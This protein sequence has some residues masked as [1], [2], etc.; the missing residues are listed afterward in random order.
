MYVE[1][2]ANDLSN[3]EYRDFLK[4]NSHFSLE[5][6]SSKENDMLISSTFHAINKKD[7]EKEV[8]NFINLFR[9]SL[10][11]N[12]VYYK[13]KNIVEGNF[14]IGYRAVVSDKENFN[15]LIEWCD[16]YQKINM[17]KSTSSESKVV[18]ENLDTMTM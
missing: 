5:I 11:I 3:D 4:K 14:F 9:N 18:D 2:V 16:N 6:A 8:D 10:D 12:A 13:D 17:P 15:N 7:D 1:K